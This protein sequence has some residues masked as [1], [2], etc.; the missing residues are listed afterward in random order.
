MSNDLHTLS[1]AYAI[2]ALSPEDALRFEKH[3][4]ACAACR[5]EVRELQEAA[6]LMAASEAQAPPPEL[7]A[8]VLA[9]ASRQP[10]LPPRVRSPRVGRFAHWTPRL[11]A[12]AAAVVLVVGAGIGF[13]V[14]QVLQDERPAIAAAVARVFDSGDVHRATMATSNGGT[15]SVATSRRLHEMAVDT[16]GLPALD[17]GQVYQLW[18][19]HDG[20][21]HSAGVLEDPAK[22]AAMPMPRAGVA[23]A[24]TIEPTGGSRQ[25]TTEP[26]MSVV[27]SDV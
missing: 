1:G 25:P 21:A 6:G 15:I 22:G 5:D 23:V 14:H 19:V 24:I 3:L 7:K 4:D 17:P 10:Q 2:D 9:A 12:A 20:S 26:I 16:A 13:T 8:R 27:P 18:A 11:I